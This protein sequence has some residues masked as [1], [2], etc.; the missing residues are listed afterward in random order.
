MVHTLRLVTDEAPHGSILV[1]PECN[2][3]VTGLE[4]IEFT[5]IQSVDD[6]K[7]LHGSLGYHL[8]GPIQTGGMGQQEPYVMQKGQIQTPVR[9]M[10]KCTATVQAKTG[11]LG[12]SSAEKDL[13]P[14][15]TVFSTLDALSSPPGVWLPQVAVFKAS[16][17][18]RVVV[19]KEL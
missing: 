15:Q 2:I 7:V 12:S 1:L 13:G 10:E 6:T 19:E 16:W 14:Q 17:L 8:E 18:S 3:F 9:G 11:W 5:L 4:E